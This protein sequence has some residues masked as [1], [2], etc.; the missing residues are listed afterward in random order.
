M[1]LVGTGDGLVELGLD[2]K[3]VRRGLPGV[4][5][6]GIGV[7]GPSPTTGS[8][9]SRTGRPGPCPRG[10]SPAASWPWRGAGRSWGAATAQVVRWAAPRPCR[11][12]GLRRHPHPPRVDHALGRPARPPLA[13]DGRRR[14]VRRRARRRR[15]APR[16]RSVDRGGAGRGRRPPGPGRRRHRRRRR[17][18]G[19]GAELGRRG[20]LALEHR[21]PP[22]RVLPGGGP[23]RGMAAGQRLDRARHP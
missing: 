5:V 20:H 15:L 14:A 16:S 9:R 18:R 21:G 4:E 2:G 10:S 13:H 23:G 22:R 8:S 17:R 3:G 6:T 1:L 19:R 12:Q 7:T 11:R